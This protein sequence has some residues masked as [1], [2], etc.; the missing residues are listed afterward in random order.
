MNHIKVPFCFDDDALVWLD[1]NA[2]LLLQEYTTNSKENG[3][4][5]FNN[6]GV[7][8]FKFKMTPPA[9]N[10][11]KFLSQ[12]GF[13]EIYPQ[14]FLYKETGALPKLENVHVDSH[15][16]GI[17][18]PARFNVVYKGDSNT[19]MYWWDQSKNQILTKTLTKNNYTRYQVPGESPSA[20]LSLIGEP[21]EISDMSG[22]V[23]NYGTF[24]RTEV[25]HA[26]HRPGIFRLMISAQIRHS[27]Q[28]VVNA[29]SGQ[30]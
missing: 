22:S 15:S 8:Y 30:K 17:L 6:F 11:I 26:L 20:Q 19:S 13:T 28:D 21:S 12:F 2:P 1:T 14:L 25:L 9:K 5:T 7:E 29:V 4:P 16:N 10:L 18:L 27:W 3:G 24:V 23:N